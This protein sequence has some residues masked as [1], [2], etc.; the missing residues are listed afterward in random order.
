MS[1]PAGWYPTPEGQE[2]YWDGQSW[3]DQ[4]R[5]TEAEGAPTPE[6]GGPPPGQ[7]GP[8]PKKSNGCLIGA[9]IAGVVVLVLILVLVAA[10]V[11]GWFVAKEKIGE[12]VASA[13]PTQSVQPEPQAPAPDATGDSTPSPE[14]TTDAPDAPAFPIGE[15]F[16]A[17]RFEIQKGWKVGEATDFPGWAVLDMKATTSESSSAPGLFTLSLLDGQKVVTE[18]LCTIEPTGTSPRKVDCMP[19]MTDPSSA[20]TA[21]VSHVL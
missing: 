5:A 21:R 7:S 8:P 2:R 14:E 3:T 13:V 17:G 9:I 6:Q 15:G 16:T 12:I 18:T 11:F 10:G 4:I 1:T 19:I 20:T